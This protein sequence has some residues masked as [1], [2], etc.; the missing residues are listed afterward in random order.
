MTEADAVKAPANPLT[1]F[2]DL[3]E[4]PQ[5]N[6]PGLPLYGR[7]D[8]MRRFGYRIVCHWHRDLEFIHVVAG[9]TT[10]FVNGET[11]RMRAGEG[12]FIN[13]R[14][15]HYL[16]S[17]DREDCRFVTAMVDPAFL[18]GLWP[19]LSRAM[20]ERMDDY[21]MLDAA[22]PSDRELLFGIDG[23]ARTMGACAHDRLRALDAV[24]QA[25]ALCS[26]ALERMGRRPEPSDVGSSA[27]SP[28]GRTDDL[29]T[30]LAMVAFVRANVASRITLDDIAR[31]GA[32]GRRRCCEL[33]RR[34]A[35]RTPNDYL[36]DYRIGRSRELL[37]GGAMTVGEI[38]AVCGFSSSAYFGYVF[39]RRMGCSPGEYRARE[40]AG[41]I[42]PVAGCRM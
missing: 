24:S 4:R 25:A 40:C 16:Y 19:D 11:R 28:A 42:E 3:S 33:F 22:D 9:G 17:D 10:L 2:S 7:R 15:L 14:R 1:V 36:T 8:D 21:V 29:R 27:V 6:L 39:R 13:S 26:G 41:R 31:A 12:V 37:V 20:L 38:A 23:F 5:Y 18:G 34:H 35:G 30:F 32:V